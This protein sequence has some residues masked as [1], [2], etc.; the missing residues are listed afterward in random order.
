LQLEA[1]TRQGIPKECP[2]R[3]GLLLRAEAIATNVTT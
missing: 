2:E 3:E 1:V